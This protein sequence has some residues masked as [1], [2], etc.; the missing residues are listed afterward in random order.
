MAV[1]GKKMM[2]TILTK[3]WHLRLQATAMMMTTVLKVR[4][5]LVLVLTADRLLEVVP[6][7]GQ[8]IVCPIAPPRGLWWLQLRTQGAVAQL[9]CRSVQ[10]RERVRCTPHRRGFADQQGTKLQSRRDGRVP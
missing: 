5:V 7:M 1:E 9:A 6:Q 3:A 8:A 2:A 4:M 10:L